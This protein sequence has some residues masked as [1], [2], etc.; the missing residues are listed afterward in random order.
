MKE[1]LTIFIAALALSMD[2]FAVAICFG[3]CAKHKSEV[4]LRVG[5][6]FGLFQGLMPLLGWGVGFLLNDYI[7]KFDYWV[8]FILLAGIGFKMIIEAITRKTENRKLNSK[9]LWVMVS[10]SVATSIDAF[11]VGLSFALIK[12][13]IFVTVVT[14]GIITFLMSYSGVHIGKKLSIKLGNKAEILGGV[15]LIAMGVKVLIEHFYYHT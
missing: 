12:I 15:I 8:V 9:N 4:A 1:I 7:H 6:Y 14:M 2:A 10:M 5:I 3:A 13:P 11:A